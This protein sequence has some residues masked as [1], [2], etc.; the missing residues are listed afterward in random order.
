MVSDFC[1]IAFTIT[2]MSLFSEFNFKIAIKTYTNID[3]L[4]TSDPDLALK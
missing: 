1:P 3:E 4:K 2:K